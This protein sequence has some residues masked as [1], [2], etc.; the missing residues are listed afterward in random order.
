MN[1]YYVI[2]DTGYSGYEIGNIIEAT[3]E[4]EAKEKAVQEAKEQLYDMIK[5]LHVTNIEEY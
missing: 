3:S 2:V 5:R 4:K 1:E